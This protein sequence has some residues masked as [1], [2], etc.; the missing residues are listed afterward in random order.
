MQGRVFP[1]MIFRDKGPAKNCLHL[2]VLDPCLIGQCPPPGNGLDLRRCFSGGAASE[3]RQDGE[4][5]ARKG[6]VVV[7]MNYRLGIFG[8]FTHPTSP[9]SPATTPPATMD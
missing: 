9:K 3:P 8:F 4:S 5:L 7:S 1:D 6:I 2:N